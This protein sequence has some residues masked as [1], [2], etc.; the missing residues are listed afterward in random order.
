MNFFDN[1][2][3]HQSA[4]HIQLLHYLLILIKFLFLPFLSLILVGTFISLWFWKKGLKENNHLYIQFAKDV[5]DIFTINKSFGLALGILPLITSI[6][7]FAQLLYKSYSAAIVILMT[8]LPLLVLGIL[9]IYILKYSMTFNELFNE[10]GLTSQ[11]NDSVQEKLRKFSKGSNQLARRSG[12]IGFALL[13]VGAWYYVSAVNSAVLAENWVNGNH[14]SLL[15]SAEAMLNFIQFLLVAVA[16]AGATILFVFF[17]WDGGRKNT[18]EDYKNFIKKFGL[19]ITLVSLILIPAILF[20]NNLLLPKTSY[21]GAVFSYLFITIALIFFLYHL[22]YAISKTSNF[23]MSGQLF[24]VLIFMILVLIIKEE[25]VVTNS[26]KLH[27]AVL[28]NDFNKYLSS[29]KGEDVSKVQGRSGEEIFNVICSTCHKFDE[30]LVGPPYNKVL[31]K[32][33]G[34]MD[35]L[36]AFIRNPVKI[37]PAYPPMPN[38]GLTPTEARN[39]ADYI[40]NQHMKSTEKK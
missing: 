2:V 18:T 14:I 11:L 10:L 15:F 35:Q 6:L 20:I 7:I 26:T 1:I 4:E 34:K 36:V 40:M 9:L 30:K 22:L 17:Y 23:K 27:S 3:L 37:D 19:T 38:Q 29:L 13:I 24:F 25:I 5:I 28:S 21:S 16:L 33:E 8:A 39:I 31:V 12:I 32:Y